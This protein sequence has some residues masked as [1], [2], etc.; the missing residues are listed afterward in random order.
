MKKM[1]KLLATFVCLVMVTTILSACTSTSTGNSK[2]AEEPTSEPTES[3]TT[4]EPTEAPTEEPTTEPTEQPTESVTTATFAEEDVILTLYTPGVEAS[5]MDPFEMYQTINFVSN[6]FIQGTDK[7]ASDGG[8]VY[9]LTADVVETFQ[10]HAHPTMYPEDTGLYDAV[11]Y[12]YD[13]QG[14]VSIYS[15]VGDEKSYLPAC[16]PL[17]YNQ[18]RGCLVAYTIEFVDGTQTPS[19][20]KL[21][22]FYYDPIALRLVPVDANPADYGL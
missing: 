9:Q 5:S 19:T 4:T 15:E 6:Y 18:T 14:Y 1:K 8:S 3:V 21:Q 7:T 13:L 16:V 2:P 10:L 22:E 17:W 20:Y 11:F 12:L